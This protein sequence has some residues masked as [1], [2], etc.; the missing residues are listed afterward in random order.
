MRVN[1]L[2]VNFSIT[3]Y[4]F[5]NEKNNISYFSKLYKFGAA[6]AN[7]SIKRNCKGCKNR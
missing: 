5:K 6:G 2:I 4:Q 7:G 3:L 1:V